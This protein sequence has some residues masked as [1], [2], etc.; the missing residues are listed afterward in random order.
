MWPDI[1]Q[2]DAKWTSGY[3]VVEDFWLDKCGDGKVQLNPQMAQ[4]DDGN[5][6]SGDGWSKDCYIE[7]GYSWDILSNQNNKSYWYKMCG[8]GKYDPANN[9]FCDDGNYVSGDG[10]KR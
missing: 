1:S 4:W 3:E 10:C 6:N 7:A 5:N 9:E 2:K 8:N